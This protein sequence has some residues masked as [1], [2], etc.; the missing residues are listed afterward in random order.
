[1]DMKKLPCGK[2]TNQPT[3]KGH[4]AHYKSCKSPACRARKAVFGALAGLHSARLSP[5]N[6]G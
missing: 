5:E 6:G 3:L 4:L 1:M 2:T